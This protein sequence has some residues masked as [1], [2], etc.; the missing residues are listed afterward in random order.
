MRVNRD[1]LRRAVALGGLALLLGAGARASTF[2]PISDSE[3]YRRAD[4]VVHALVLGNEV[5]EGPSGDPETRTTLAPLRFLKGGPEGRIVLRQL[6]GELPDGRG[7]LLWGRPEY[8]PGG[9]VLVF[10]IRNADGSL[11]TAELM[12]GKFEIWTDANGDLFAVPDIARGVHEGVTVQPD[13]VGGELSAPRP[14]AEFLAYLAGGAPGE[15]AALTGPVGFL[16]PVH[17]DEVER[18]PN[19]GHINNS[20]YRFSN[21]TA[22]WSLDGA[23][24]ITGGGSAEAAGALASWTNDPNS[25]IQFSVGSGS[26]PMHMNALSSPC[27]WTT[28]LSGGGVIGCGGPRTISGSHTWRGDTYSNITSG[29]VWLRAY[30]SLNGFSSTITESVLVHEVGHA[31]GLGHSDQNV[32]THDVC[33][34]DE[35]AASMRSSVQNRRTIGTDDQDAIRWIYGDGGNHCTASSP[36]TIATVAPAAG[37]AAGGTWVTIAGTNF[38]PGATVTVG[39]V[40]ATVQGTIFPTSI[41]ASTGGHA[42]GTVNVVVTNPDTQAATSTNGFFY[43]F[44]DVPPAHTY[45]AFINNIHRNGVTSGCGGNAYC[46]NSSVSRAEMSVFLLRADEGAAYNPPAATGSVFADVPSGGFAAAWIEEIF[47]RGIT[48]GCTGGNFCPN[49]AVTRE[50]MA[51]FLLRTKYGAA[52]NP[53]A[54]TGDFLDVPIASGYAPWIEQLAA[55]GITSGCGGGN[56]CPT[57]AV[58]R[59]HMAV[60]LVATFSLLP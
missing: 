24:N 37:S 58:T 39:G 22:V 6:G 2:I 19:W 49:A 12:L 38:V 29:E 3:L 18:A 17:H 23:A 53:P 55:E 1:G 9:E 42:V 4:L 33:T 56:Y 14:L 34:G 13:E 36:P 40:P 28:C 27:G 43:H 11:Q 35:S 41:V 44:T 7:F 50:Q 15:F 48:A 10:A 57:Q 31:M 32:S 30:C 52:Y 59:A 5:V 46:P 54:A 51:V 25:T 47:D 8:V 60:F 26:S 20:R 16:S 21:P 45:Y